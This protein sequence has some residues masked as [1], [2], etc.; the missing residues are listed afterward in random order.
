MAMIVNSLPNKVIARELGVCQRTAARI[1][2]DVFEKMG[3]ESAV[4]S[5][6]MSVALVGLP[7]RECPR[8]GEMRVLSDHHTKLGAVH[9]GRRIQAGA[10]R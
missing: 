2:A 4:E 5:A 7:Q 10:T 3:A 6:Q 8:T 9:A 1:R